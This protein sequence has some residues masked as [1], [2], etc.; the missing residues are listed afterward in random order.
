MQGHP[1]DQQ[2]KALVR[3]MQP[4]GMLALYEAE[5][6]VQNADGTVDVRPTADALGVGLSSVPVALQGAANVRVQPGARCVLAF[7][8]GRPDRPVV[9]FYLSATFVEAELDAQTIK[10][11]PTATSVRLGKGLKPVAAQGDTTDLAA[12]G[13]P[14]T[15]GVGSGAVANVVVKV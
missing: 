1:L 15:I 8:D 2:L 9:L 6:V 12:N 4:V 13:K 5:V 11:G 14:S 10:I 7:L 3:H